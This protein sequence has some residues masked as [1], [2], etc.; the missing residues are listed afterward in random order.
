MKKI[1]T[2]V[3]NIGAGKT[4]ATDILKKHLTE[5]SF[6]DADTLFQ[7]T[8][9][10][11]ER[12]LEDMS[13]WAFCNEMWLTLERFKLT[14]QHLANNTSTFTIIDSGLLMSWVYMYSHYLKKVI[15]KEEWD[16][17][18]NM[19]SHLTREVTSV[20]TVIHL[21]YTIPTLLKRIQKRGRDYELQYY[22]NEYLEQLEE[23]L[24]GLRKKLHDEGTP[25]ITISEKE[26]A[27]F[28]HN[29]D[30]KKIMIEKF[31]QELK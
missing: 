1:I 20:M 29:S 5:A 14:K 6:L 30:D 18:A 27:D 31:K 9:P 28:E 23:G 16:L 7:T 8:D 10:F 17:Y 13:R 3:G 15:T 2:I 19:Y 24:Q 26:V 11:R 22:T 25:I 21:D 12:F 4:T